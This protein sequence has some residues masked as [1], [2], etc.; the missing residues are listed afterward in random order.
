MCWQGYQIIDVLSLPLDNIAV[1]AIIIIVV[2]KCIELK[3]IFTPMPP[4]R[5]FVCNLFS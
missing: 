1:L 3:I 5:T 4:F 2:V